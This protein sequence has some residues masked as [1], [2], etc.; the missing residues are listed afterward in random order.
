MYSE[1]LKIKIGSVHVRRRM[2]S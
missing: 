2:Q 1:Q